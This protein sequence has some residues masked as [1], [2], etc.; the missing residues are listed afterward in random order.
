MNQY[1]ESIDDTFSSP[2]LKA[3]DLPDEGLAVEISEVDFQIFGKGRRQREKTN[4]L[5][6]WAQ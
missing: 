4:P 1:D 2:F 5:I 6:G 3:A